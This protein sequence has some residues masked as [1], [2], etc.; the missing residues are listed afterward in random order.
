PPLAADA[1]R[2]AARP[3]AGDGGDAAPL[4]GLACGGRTR[5][6]SRRG[7]LHVDGRRSAGARPRCRSRRRRGDHERSPHPRGL[8]SRVVSRAFAIVAATLAL[9]A[10]GVLLAVVPAGSAQ[11]PPTTT[12]TDTTTSTTTE[13]T[14][15]TTTTTTTTPAPKPRPQPRV[16]PQGVTIGGIHV[17]GL[18]PG[19]AHAGARA[20]FRSALVL[21]VGAH[22]E[23]VSPTELGAVAY[24]KAAVAR[25]RSAR[26][27]T[28]I[29]LGVSVRGS[30][31]RK[32]VDYL[33]QRFNHD[34]VDSKVL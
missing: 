1:N 33:A 7:G 25:A 10:A 11:S 2:A 8:H 32:V 15:T 26:P 21:T 13:T 20:A 30:A 19:A 16:L 17:G 3:C 24:A 9:A 22:K 34:P 14:S 12:G 4:G 28:A 6:P 18:S 27:G 5:A 31:V 29:A 23:F